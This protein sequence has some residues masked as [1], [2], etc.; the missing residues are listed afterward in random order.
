MGNETLIGDQMLEC[1][2]LANGTASIE[3]VTNLIP[4]SPNCT[5]SKGETHEKEEQWVAFCLAMTLSR[6]SEH[7]LIFRLMENWK[8]S[9]SAA[10]TAALNLT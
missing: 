6:L 7:R 9:V 5:D 2:R 3:P 10:R 4:F 8:W 1:K